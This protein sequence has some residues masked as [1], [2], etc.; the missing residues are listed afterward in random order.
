MGRSE[1]RPILGPFVAFPHLSIHK[2][3]IILQSNMTP[4]GKAEQNGKTPICYNGGSTWGP[5]ES[6]TIT[7]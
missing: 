6:P 2:E 5:R 3:L 1:P 7:S 4:I